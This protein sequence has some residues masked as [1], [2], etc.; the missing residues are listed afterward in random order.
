MAIEVKG[1][2]E[3]E[4]NLLKLKSKDATRVLRAG[5]LRAAKP[6]EAQ[7]KQNAA[8]ISQ[9]SG[10]LEKSIGSQFQVGGRE[11]E[12]SIAAILPNLGGRFSVV[13]GPLRRSKVAVALYNLFYK[14]RRRDI[15]HGH[16]V[17]FPTKRT[18]AQPFL[19]PALD[20]K[21]PG[22][23]QILADEIKAGIDRMLKRK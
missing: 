14:R 3:V 13:I 19:K 6:I 22:A 10:A 8:S 21:G 11:S 12:F 20:A 4:Q 18:S 7:A 5:M 9:G 17:E 1:L 15:Y 16:L 2:R 23:V